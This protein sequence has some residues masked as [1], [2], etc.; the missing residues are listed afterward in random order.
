MSSE[1]AEVAEPM[2]APVE[3]VEAPPAEVVDAAAPEPVAFGAASRD[4]RAEFQP[5]EWAG[6]PEATRAKVEAMGR[7]LGDLDGGIR[8]V[9]SKLDQQ[10]EARIAAEARAKAF[11]E[12]RASAPASPAPPKFSDVQI[13]NALAANIDQLNQLRAGG[14]DTRDVEHRISVL[15]GEIARRQEDARQQSIVET[16]REEMRRELQGALAPVHEMRAAQE[17]D[18]WFGDLA[19]KFQIP[20]TTVQAVVAKVDKLIEADVG[21]L[22]EF[23]RQFPDL[24]AMIRTKAHESALMVFKSGIGAPATNPGS[25]APARPNPG[26]PSQGSR[27]AAM[28]T[29]AAGVN[30]TPGQPW[31]RGLNRGT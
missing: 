12:L 23:Q 30:R 9:T 19:Q 17:E 7:L 5:D 22:G 26:L 3:G 20:K 13:G 11:E 10:R 27:S 18:R 15:R 29:P 25:G 21:P 28:A 14:Y 8:S 16:L 2:S 6:I 4:F 31:L 24:A 1:F